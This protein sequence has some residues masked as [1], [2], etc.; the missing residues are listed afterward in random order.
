[1]ERATDLL[2]KGRPTVGGNLGRHSPPHRHGGGAQVRAESLPASRERGRQQHACVRVGRPRRGL[3]DAR[4]PDRGTKR[5]GVVTG[6][7]EGSG[8]PAS[9]G[10]AIAWQ[11]A[12]LGMKA[13]AQ[14]APPP[15]GVVE[16]VT[17]EGTRRSFRWP[18]LHAPSAAA[19]TRHVSIA[20]IRPSWHK[21]NANITPVHRCQTQI[22]KQ[23]CQ[24]AATFEAVVAAADVVVAE[25]TGADEVVE[26]LAARTVA[27]ARRKTSLILTS[28]WTRL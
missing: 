17:V 15:V 23:P 20:Q 7:S 26:V 21:P 28:T 13:A 3:A 12:R 9:P 1:M 14:K 24:N 2:R 4:P 5:L 22:N 16:P 27:S 6:G 10:M 11:P 18:E 19:V 8:A 25:E